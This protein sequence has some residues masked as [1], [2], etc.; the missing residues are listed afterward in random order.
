MNVLTRVIQKWMWLSIPFTVVISGCSIIGLTLGLMSDARQPKEMII[1]GWKVDSL[2]VGTMIEVLCKD[3]ITLKGKYSGVEPLPLG[4]YAQAYAKAQARLPAG[5][6][7]PDLA[8]T[9]TMTFVSPNLQVSKRVLS[10]KLSGFE[11]GF[12]L[13]TTT[14]NGRFKVS[15][16]RL[17][18]LMRLRD[19]RGT[20][21]T[22]EIVS[23]LITEGK[24]P[25]RS[26][27][28]LL[29][30]GRR[31]PVAINQV[32]QVHQ[33]AGKKNGAITG[34]LLG[35]VIDATLVFIAVHEVDDSFKNMDWGEH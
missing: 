11:V 13:F 1:P 34:L 21:L 28:V 26:A 9:L 35:A 15:S 3:S 19:E 31:K 33:F 14:E 6:H 4:Q 20:D 27:L 10:G 7:L 17:E 22:G 29:D 18:E 12:I 16:E 8:D 24:I 2:K 30:E 25:A 5:I 23:N 32:E